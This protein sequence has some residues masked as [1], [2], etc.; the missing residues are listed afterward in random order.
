MSDLKNFKSLYKDGLIPTEEFHE[1]SAAVHEDLNKIFEKYI[2][3]GYSPREI[4]ELIFTCT[5]HVASSKAIILTVEQLRQKK[6]KIVLTPS[7][8]TV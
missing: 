3:A 6:K 7:T 5:G 4:S 8:D 2:K 1:I